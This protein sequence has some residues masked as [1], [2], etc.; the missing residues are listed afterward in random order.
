MVYPSFNYLSI[1]ERCRADI[2]QFFKLNNLSDLNNFKQYLDCKEFL[3]DITDN[4]NLES[5]KHVFIK[6]ILS[7]LLGFSTKFNYN[8]SINELNK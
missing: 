8:T 4:Y 6:R 1:E 7:N 2:T 3:F 5:I